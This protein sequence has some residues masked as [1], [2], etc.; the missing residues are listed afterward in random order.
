M[1]REVEDVTF[2]GRL[3]TYRYSN[4]DEVVGSALHAAERIAG[5]L[6]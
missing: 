4:M 6:A 1:A 2:L 3:A 5:K